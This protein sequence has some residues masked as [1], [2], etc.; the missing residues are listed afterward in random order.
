MFEIRLDDLTG[1]QLVALLNEHIAD[2]QSIS[3]PES[4]HALDLSGLQ[5][6]SVKFWSVWLGD[7]LAGC[8]AYKKLSN[9]QAEIKSMRTASDFRGQ[10]V[11]SILLKHLI[12]DAKINGYQELSLET[13]SMVYFKPAHKLYQKYGFN[14][15]GPFADYSEDPN[16]VFMTLK[17][18]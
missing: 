3:P 1:Q 5:H 4:K 9:T 11:A 13:G 14:F 6:P 16:S 8:G 12:E 15:C 2:M 10:G 17:L 7:R 18:T